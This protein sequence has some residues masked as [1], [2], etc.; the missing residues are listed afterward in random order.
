MAECDWII[1]CDYAFPSMHGKLG[2]IGIFDTIYAKALPVTHP[3]AAIGFAIIGEPGER[4]QPKLE[5][6]SPMG[7]VLATAKLGSIELP[8]QGGAFAHVDLAGLKLS[9][10]GRH[11]IQIDLGDDVSKSAWFT[12][13]KIEG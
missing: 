11:A 1:L 3:R 2:L 12:L 9:D 8:N 10:W 5:I 4:V 6:I 13:R 7:K